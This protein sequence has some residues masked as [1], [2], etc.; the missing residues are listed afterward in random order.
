MRCIGVLLVCAAVACAQDPFEIHVYEYDPLPLGSFTYESHLNYAFAGATTYDGTVAPTQRQF[1]L[2][3]ELTAGLSESLALGTMLL[4]AVRPD[5]SL[6]YA[7]WRV[8][9]H[10]LAPKS[11]RLPVNLDVLAEFSFERPQFELDSRHLELRLVV[12]KHIG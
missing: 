4:T 7:G 1:H 9:P 6:E 10:V 5:Q 3:S 2:P 8:I 12:E 11:W